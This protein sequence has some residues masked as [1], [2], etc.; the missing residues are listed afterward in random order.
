[1]SAILTARNRVKHE[2]RQAN[3]VLQDASSSSILSTLMSSSASWHNDNQQYAFPESHSR[4]IREDKASTT[5][6]PI[7]A[8]LEP[9]VIRRIVGVGFRV[10]R[11]QWETRS[12]DYS[13][14]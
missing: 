9:C 6:K 3:V 4:M 5:L 14:R 2:A 11:R 12:T 13:A 8:I 1:M 7:G 10:C